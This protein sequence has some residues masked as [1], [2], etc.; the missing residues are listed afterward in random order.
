[1][2]QCSGRRSSLY[3]TAADT[4]IYFIDMKLALRQRTPL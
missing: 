1:V 4:D 2:A 3:I